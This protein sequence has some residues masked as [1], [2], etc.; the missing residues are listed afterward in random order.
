[1]LVHNLNPQVKFVHSKDKIQ[2]LSIS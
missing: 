2:V 1:L